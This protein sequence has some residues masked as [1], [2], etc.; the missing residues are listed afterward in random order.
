MRLPIELLVSFYK[1]ILFLIMCICVS[2]C[3]YV[4]LSAFVHR[5]QERVPDPLE[6]KLQ[7]IVSHP[8]WMQ[9]TKPLFL[10]EQEELLINNPSLHEPVF[11]AKLASAPNF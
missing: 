9:G 6:L 2:V 8:T 5:A 11:S 4:H 10:Q 7:V 1:N 3:R